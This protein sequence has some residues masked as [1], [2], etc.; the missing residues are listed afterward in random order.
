MEVDGK[1]VDGY[2]HIV[3]LPYKQL[4]VQ[5]LNLPIPQVRVQVPKE[6]AVEVGGGE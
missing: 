4:F 6:D 5:F 1:E 2:P 3:S